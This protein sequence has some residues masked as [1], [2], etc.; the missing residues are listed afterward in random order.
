VR[1]ALRAPRATHGARVIAVGA[2]AYLLLAPLLATIHEVLVLA[3][4]A[5]VRAFG[6]W[7]PTALLPLLPVDPI[8]GGAAL[9]LVGGIEPRGLAMAGPLGDALH[10]AWPDLFAGSQVVPPGAVASAVL[11][12]GATVFARTLAILAA[13]VP[14]LTLGIAVARS[15]RAPAWVGFGALLLQAHLLT[16][17][18]VDGRLSLRELEA[19]GL[20]FAVAA[21]APVGAGG[22]LALF[23]RQLEGTSDVIIAIGGGPDPSREARAD[24]FAS[25]Y[26]ELIDAIHALDPNHPVVYRDAEDLYFAGSGGS[27]R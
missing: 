10:A 2:G 25:F 15:G 27:G 11:V 22:Q 24:A 6:E 26:V 13:T 9:H 16:D 17:V 8:Y 23:T 14:M 21:L 3:A 19:T 5:I 18:V 12:G 20:P 4:A 7:S 1:P